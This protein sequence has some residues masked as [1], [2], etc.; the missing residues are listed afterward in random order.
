MDIH[1][2]HAEGSDQFPNATHYHLDDN[3][4]TLRVI[5]GQDNI[6]YSPNFWQSF[7]V[8]PKSNDPLN[9]EMR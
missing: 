5:T 8:D 4:G 3:N 2:R 7:A 6:G 9:L 1:I